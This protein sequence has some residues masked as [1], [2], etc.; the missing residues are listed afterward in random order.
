[1]R[2]RTAASVV[3]SPVLVGAVTVLIVI[4]AVF[5]AYNANK[6]LPF[7]PT[8][9]L[10]AEVPGAANLV[11]GNEVRVGGFRVGVVD[12]IK[13]GRDD[14][15]GRNL[16]V[17][18]MKLDK[19]VE[20]LATDTQV[21]VRP[22][23]AL[24]LKYV[25]LAP[26]RS[27]ETF[28]AG[29]TIPL[30][31]AK[32]VVE[33][34]DFLSI[35]DEKTRE[36]S[37]T[38]LKGYGDAL[39]GRGPSLNAA[40]EALNPFF[41]YLTPVM[42]NLN[43]PDTELDEFF[44]QIGRASAQVAPV[45][46]TQAELFTHMADTFDAIGRSP[47][48]L[49]ATI[50]KAPGT[51]ATGTTSFRVQAPFY[52][53]FAELSR[54]LRPAARELPRSLPKINRALVVGQ[55]VL[56]RSVELNQRTER[57]FA[58]L[59]DLAEN[60]NTLLGIKDLR[61]T[62]TVTAPLVEFVAP[63]ETVCNY[64]NSFFDSLGKIFSEDVPEGTTF[65]VLIASDNRQ[66]DNRPSD[67]PADRPPDVPSDRDPQDENAFPAGPRVALHGNPYAPA[68][69]AAGNADCQGG[70]TGYLDGPLADGGRYPPAPASSDFDANRAGGSHVV[71]NPDLPGLAG[72][73]YKGREL[74]IDN[75][76]DVP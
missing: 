65:R 18:E 12:E 49:Q 4:V 67:Y 46:R 13:P 41:A 72:P 34:D 68:I 73:T 32:E 50:E 55:P 39:A 5:L 28:D 19:K 43:D 25:E 71:I 15:T 7:V 64:T 22:R 38:G 1:M 74:G 53:D 6:G 48:A 33:F 16:A 52:A 21:V 54:R 17:L 56:R 66:Q 69:D 26:G 2:N 9:E 59:D 36:N 10:K 24:G 20:P 58:A 14:E 40:I 3:A 35:F 11:P 8:Y 37:R 44:K 45:A 61:T 27:R 42:D 23:S 30:A 63:Y 76:K 51:L 75:L 29:D 57:V 70:Q 47:R 60:P 31:N 62:V